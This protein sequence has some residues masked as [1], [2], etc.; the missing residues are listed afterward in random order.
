MSPGMHDG[1]VRAFVIPM[2]PTTT[3]KELVPL[4]SFSFGW[5]VGRFSSTD[6]HLFEFLDHG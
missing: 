6:H 1:R 3:K 4:F 2:P 5:K